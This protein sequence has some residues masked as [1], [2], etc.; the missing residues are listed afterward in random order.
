MRQR[1]DINITSVNH[2]QV[3]CCFVIKSLRCVCARIDDGD[4]ERYAVS[5]YRACICLFVCSGRMHQYT[6]HCVLYIR[7]VHWCATMYLLV[8][9]YQVKRMHTSSALNK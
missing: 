9:V 1:K 2:H 7:A 4:D 6:G 5:V 8:I 3:I